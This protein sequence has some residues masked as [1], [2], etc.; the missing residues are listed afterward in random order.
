VTSSSTA[1]QKHFPTCVMADPF[2]A[3]P[4]ASKCGG[5]NPAGI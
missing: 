2:E 3:R 1:P 5:T 4:F